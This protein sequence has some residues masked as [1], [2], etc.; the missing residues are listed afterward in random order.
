MSHLV[1]VR[2]PQGLK[3]YR[4]ASP[5]TP[6]ATAVAT[7]AASTA[8]ASIQTSGG[9]LVMTNRPQQPQQPLQPQ[10]TQHPSPLQS[11]VETGNGS[12]VVQ[13]QTG[14]SEDT[15]IVRNSDGRYVQM[16][17]S[18][19]KKLINSGQL[20]QSN[21]SNNSNNSNNLNSSNNSS[22]V[23][24]TLVNSNPVT[25]QPPS[26]ETLGPRFSSNDV[27]NLLPTVPVRQ[28]HLQHD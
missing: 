14:S 3:L 17:R 27:L 25:P 23:P 9:R 7:P 20:K 1:Q 10:Q 21:T 15:V 18:I 19:L 8:A 5:G 4:L 26:T 2:T 24:S 28:E 13:S 16:P 11:V 22:V 12:Q 6:G